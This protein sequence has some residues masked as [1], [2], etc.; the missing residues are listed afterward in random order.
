MKKAYLLLMALAVFVSAL[1]FQV[2]R[3][4]ADGYIIYEDAQYVVGTG[5]LF[6]FEAEGFR[7]KDLKNATIYVGSDFY[8]LYCWVRKQE[9][10]ILC[11]AWGSLTQFAGQTG[12]IYLG[13]QIFY[14]IIP[15]RHGTPGAGGQPPTC[16]QGEL[17]GAEYMVDFGSGYEGPYFVPGDTLDEADQ[18][19]G[20][21]F[22]EFDYY[23]VNGLVC[24]EEPQ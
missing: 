24:G 7:N 22:G 12:V 21:W 17:L 2:N 6:T 1:G 18:Q 14:V 3:A 20:S 23:R 5:I 19:A 16:E 11:V 15:N 4:R 8:D 9:G 13:G 10:K